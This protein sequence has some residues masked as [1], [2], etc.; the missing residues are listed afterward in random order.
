M[1]GNFDYL[2]SLITPITERF[3]EAN[4]KLF[5][6]GGVVRDALINEK[7]SSP[8]LD[9]TTD[10]TPDQIR[11]LVEPLADA[12]WLQGERFGTIGLKFKDLRME[13][14]THRSESYVSASRKP[15][16]TFSLDI[17]DDLSRRDFTV[18][19][20]A[21]AVDSGNFLDPFNGKS[22]LEDRVLR[23]P[24]APYESFNDDPLRMLRAARFIASYELTPVKEIVDTAKELVGRISIVS[25][26]RIR[27]ELLK[28]LSL[29]NPR[30]GFEF[31]EQIDLL[32]LIFPFETS[33]NIKNLDKTFELLTPND[34]VMRLSVFLYGISKTDISKSLKDLR[35]SR[36]E[37]RK[38]ENIAEFLKKISEGPN[39]NN[40]SNEEIRRIMDLSDWSI[41]DSVRLL[42]ALDFNDSDFLHSLHDLNSTEDLTSFESPLSALEVM[43]LL[44]LSP[45]P[46]VGQVLFWLKEIR[47]KEGPIAPEEAKSRVLQ[48]W[49]E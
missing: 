39:S 1:I 16:V 23:T 18:N 24:I 35:M 17:E 49:K 2:R 45:G 32:S 36:D 38:I 21:I 47:L 8:D 46:V 25:P 13:I 34:P 20:M 28:L 7:M 15:S 19:A 48:E 27:E 26:E 37:I 22:D 11:H 3:V 12:V 33:L 10:A 31:L 40:W 14:T 6:V 44:D 41:Q 5:L 43:D 42:E 30:K 4:Y 9:L 29:K